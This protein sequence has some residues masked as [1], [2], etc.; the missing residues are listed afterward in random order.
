RTEIIATL[1]TMAGEVRAGS[2]A[3]KPR[4][5][6]RRWYVAAFVALLAQ[7]VGART[8]SAVDVLL[9]WSRI[10]GASTYSVYVR[11]DTKAFVKTPGPDG[12][13]ITSALVNEAL[14]IGEA[15]TANES[16]DGTFN[17]L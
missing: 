16:I 9:S 2:R 8:A 10:A 11:Y 3:L 1:R 12:S 5:G 6:R 13:G 4:A 15:D 17:G 7:C 14:R